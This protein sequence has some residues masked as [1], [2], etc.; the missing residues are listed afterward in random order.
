MVR[1]TLV[2]CLAF[3][4]CVS[5]VSAETLF[6]DD[7]E[8]GLGEWTESVEYDWTTEYPAE[9]QVPGHTT[10]NDVA[11]ADNC[12]TG[13]YLTL[14]DAIDL[15]DYEDVTLEFYR[16]VD[17]AL[18]SGEYLK[19]EAYDGSSWNQI[20]YWTHGSGDDDTWHLESWDVPVGYLSEDFKV[21]YIAKMSGSREDAEIDDV[22][23]TG[24][25][26]AFCGNNVTEGNETCDGPDLG[27]QTCVTQGFDG[28]TLGCNAYCTGYDTSGCWSNSCAETDS[29]NDIW[30][31]G[32]TYGTLNGSGYND[33]DYCEN[34][35][36]VFEYYCS[37]DFKLSAST[38]CGT[39]TSNNYCQNGSVWT[40]TTDYYCA[41]GEC[42]VSTS[43]TFTEWCQYGCTA[44][45]CNA[46]P[47]TCTDTDGGFVVYTAG[48]VYG[49]LNGTPYNYTDTCGG[50]ALQEWYCSSGFAYSSWFNCSMNGTGCTNGACY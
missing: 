23:L 12:D 28:G 32:T 3:L 48:N 31:V 43:Q 17:K 38:S 25:L 33:T 46:P 4:L 15:S 7:F 5:F 39:D 21:R 40:N 2:L 6:S 9:K 1:K 45:V 34:N 36:T 19:V 49:S 10:G 16:Y 42:E 47:N 44:G 35:A 8:S 24:T 14:T 11:H 13:C 50:P 22:E 41:V 26:E 20:Y 29:G 30:N 27:N 37:G 18:D